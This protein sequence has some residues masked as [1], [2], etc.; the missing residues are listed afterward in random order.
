[1]G[2]LEI[3]ARFDSLLEEYGKLL[4]HAI[5]AHC[6][7]NLGLHADDLMQDACL[8]LWRALS[9]EREIHNV[10][11]YLHRIAATV[12]IDAIRRVKARHEEQMHFSPEQDRE[13][14]GMEEF[15]QPVDARRSPEVVTE[16][17]RLIATVRVILDRLP[18][19]RRRAVGLHLQ[20]FTTSEI[21]E[22]LGWREAK[23][24]NL[25]YRG[26]DD[27]RRELRGQGLDYENE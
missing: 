22:L 15:S 3:E 9:S 24:R 19:N 11:S 10:P 27:L 18:A 6:P 25:V 23:A 20:G 12:T 13:T 26:L 1:M 2:Q 21:G 17:Q 7:K 8:R 4:R 16:R 5:A 14:G